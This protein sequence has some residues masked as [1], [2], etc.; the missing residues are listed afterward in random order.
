MARRPRGHG[1]VRRARG[2]LGGRTPQGD[3]AP[4]QHGEEAA[5]RA[6]ETQGVAE[7]VLE[8]LGRPAIRALPGD[9]RF[10]GGRRLA[11][12]VESGEAGPDRAQSGGA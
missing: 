12:M 10:R 2:D 11:M 7:P 6:G 3:A 8:N 1:P 5:G 9:E 4:L